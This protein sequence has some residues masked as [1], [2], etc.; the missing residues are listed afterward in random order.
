MN[1]TGTATTDAQGAAPPPAPTSPPTLGSNSPQ[2]VSNPAPPAEPSRSDALVFFGATGDLAYKQIFPALQAMVKRGHLDV[3]VIAVAGST[4]TDDQIRARA[5]DSLEHGGGV[6]EEAFAKLAGLLHYVGGDYNDPGTYQKLKQAVGTAARPLHYLAIPPALFATVTAGLAQAG[7][8]EQARVVVEKPFG[9]DLAS[10]QELNRTLKHYFSEAAIFRIDHYLGKEPV[11]NLLFFRFAN[12]FLDPIWNRNY[13][14]S[15]QITMAENFGVAD[16]GKFYDSVGAIRDVVQNH[17]LQV[18]ALLAMEPPSP[19][20]PDGERDQKSLL[21]KSICPLNPADVALGQYKGFTAEPGVASDSQTE[22]FAAVRLS[23]DNWRWAGVPFYIRAGKWLPVTSTEVIVQLKHPPLDVFA[24]PSNEPRNFMRFRLSPDVLIAINTQAKKP[25][26]QMEG[27]TVEL[28]VRYQPSDVMAPYE[29]LLGDA[30]RGDSTLFTRED[31]VEAAW[32]VVDP[33]LSN[34]PPLH[35]Y[36]QN[37]WGPS[38]TDADIRPPAGW[39]NPV[40]S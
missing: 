32:R 33:V 4:L 29:R 40:A 15:V 16:R 20:N 17:L 37:S 9:H 18:T 22:T 25:G 5:R 34:P 7:L 14:E 26:E 23:I 1:D 8:A 10:A 38:D 3:P 24:G 27:E 39:H 2:S 6:D 12:A 36:D 19:N 21:L 30:M 13:V 31:A 28:V 35:E 11:Q